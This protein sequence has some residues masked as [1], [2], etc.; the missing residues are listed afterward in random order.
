[1]TGIVNFGVNT[2]GHILLPEQCLALK[3]VWRG[4]WEGNLTPGSGDAT[5][6]AGNPLNF[7]L[8]SKKGS[9]IPKAELEEHGMQL[10]SLYL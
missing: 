9:E 7:K 4:S 1:M 2:T 10:I 3:L 6:Q 8:E 5:I